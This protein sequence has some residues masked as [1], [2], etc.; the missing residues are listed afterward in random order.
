MSVR[1]IPPTEWSSFLVQFSRE[2]RAWRATISGI[3]RGVPITRIPSEPIKSITLEQ[4]GPDPVVRLTLVNGLSLCVQRPSAVRVQQNGDGAE[5]ALEVETADGALI[6][7]AFRAT[8]RPEQLDG[9]AP[10]E[11]G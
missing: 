10:G 1:E 2:H 6:R 4:R 5:R 8:A 7:L 3:E 11:L 9:I